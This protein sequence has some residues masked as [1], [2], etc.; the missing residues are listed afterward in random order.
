MWNSDVAIWVYASGF[1]VVVYVVNPRVMEF[2]SGVSVVHYLANS[3]H[4]L[5]LIETKI[6]QLASIEHR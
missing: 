1:D 5:I 2:H 6:K 3:Q 4:E